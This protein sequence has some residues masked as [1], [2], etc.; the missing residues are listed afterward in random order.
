MK[1]LQRY[2]G[3]TVFTVYMNHQTEG[4]DITETSIESKN[5]TIEV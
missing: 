5:S 1:A 2:Q 3:S 4:D